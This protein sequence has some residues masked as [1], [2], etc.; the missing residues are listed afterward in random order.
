MHVEHLYLMFAAVVFGVSLAATAILA[1]G[2][3]GP[4]IRRILAA[5]GCCVILVGVVAL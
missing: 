2:I 3:L 4:S 5:L 1:D